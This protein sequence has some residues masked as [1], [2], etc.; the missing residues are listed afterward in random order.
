M[1]KH[2]L[3]GGD[4]IMKYSIDKI[5]LQFK[6]IKTDRVQQFLN[7]ISNSEYQY[8]YYES[9]KIT[10][11]KH[12]FVFGDDEG[13][14]YCGVV[15]NWITEDRHDKDIVLEYNPNKINPFM[16]ECFAWLLDINKYCVKVISFDIAVDID[17]EYK[18]LR[19]LK[20]DKRESFGIMGH[21]NI[22][23]RYLG[24]LG[25]N[26][27]KLYDKAKEQKLDGIAWSR[28][29]I[30]VKDVN[31]F[32]CSEEEFTKVIKLPG[33]YSVGVQ[34]GMNEL[35]L[36]DIDRIVLESI[37]SDTQILYTIKRYET[38]KKYEKLLTEYLN[39][40]KIDI[41][42]MYN[43]FVDYGFGLFCSDDMKLIDVN[44]LLSRNSL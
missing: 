6:F 2:S 13:K 16:F 15:P 27:V 23:T 20:R 25:N 12:N 36:K 41:K 28:F 38:R 44:S 24:S 1:K 4:K 39:A 43:A 26:H 33:V 34:I 22:E 19:M 40:I 10:K 5:K 11:C 17:V 3:V 18:Y 35:N 21:S 29:E 31:S 32:F 9:M 30:T 7:S 8:E 37:I 42:K 14:I